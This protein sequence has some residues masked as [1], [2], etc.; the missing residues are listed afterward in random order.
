MISLLVG[1]FVSCDL[2]CLSV[3]LILAA[4]AKNSDMSRSPRVIPEPGD[5]KV[6]YMAA[7]GKAPRRRLVA[8]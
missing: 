7:R 5:S 3:F 4:R 2:I 1:G 8:S 6:V